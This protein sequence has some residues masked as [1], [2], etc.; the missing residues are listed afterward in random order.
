LEKSDRDFH[1][2]KFPHFHIM[3]NSLPSQQPASAGPLPF[4]GPDMTLRNVCLTLASLCL[5]PAFASAQVTAVTSPASTVNVT[6]AKDFATVAFQDPWDMKQ[7]TDLGWHIWSKDAPPSGL[8]SIA[9]NQASTALNGTDFLHAVST[10]TSPNITILESSNRFGAKLGRTG[11]AY[12]ID[13]STYTMLSY[14]LCA[15]GGGTVARKSSSFSAFSAA[16][17]NSV[18][19]VVYSPSDS[20]LGVGALGPIATFAGCQ[21]YTVDLVNV[22]KLDV[23]AG[24]K[25]WTGIIRHLR[26]DPT[27]L[28][29]VTLDLDWVRL[30]QPLGTQTI[31]WSGGGAADIYLDNNN[32]KSDGTLGMLSKNDGQQPLSRLALGV[33]SPYTFDIATL[34]PG[35]YY[36][37]VCP[38]GVAE[39]STSCLYSP[40]RFD[41]NAIPTVTVTAPSEEG[42]ADDFATVQLNNAW[43]FD[44]LSD[45]DFSQNI[46]ATSIDPAFPVQRPD[47][48]DLGTVRVLKGTPTAA[49]AGDPYFYNLFFAGSGRGVTKKIDANRYR[50]LTI[51]MGLPGARDINGGSIA[52]VVWKTT[53]ET[54][55]NVSQDILIN[56]RAGVNILDRIN[57]DMKKLLLET[58]ASSGAGP[59]SHGVAGWNGQ[60]ENF[61]FDPHEFDVVTDFWVKQV[62]LAA[63]ETVGASNTYTIKWSASDAFDSGNA[64]GAKVS[65]FY[66]TSTA[67]GDPTGSR[68]AI[69]TCVD[70]IASSGQCTW[71]T[72]NVPTGTYFIYLSINDGVNTNTV[73]SKFPMQVDPASAV[74]P[75]MVL[76][77]ALLNFGGHNVNG[78]SV[79]VTPPQQVRLSIAGSGSVGWTATTSGTAAHLFTV[80]PSSGTGPAVLTVSVPP[81]TGIPNNLV[82]ILGTVVVSSAQ[83]ENSPQSVTV[84]LA[85]T[86]APGNPFGGFDTPADNATV[87]GSIA[88][89]GWVLD[90]IGITKLEIFRDAHP[91]DPPGAIVGGKV[92]IGNATLVDGART[93]IAAAFPNAPANY[94]AGWGYLMLTRGL[95]W[96]A[97]G[98]FKLYAHATDV[99][100]HVVVLGSKTVTV[101]NSASNPEAQ[102]PFGSI[103]TPEQGGTAS[104]NYPN[105]G[106]VL[107]PGTTVPASGVRVAI[108]GV[109]LSNTFSMSDR[110]DISNGFPGFNT[111]GAGRG[112][113]IDTTQFADGVHT[114]GWFVT[115]ALGRSEGIGSR[116]FR[117]T[118][119]SSMLTTT[120]GQ[121]ALASSTTAFPKLGEVAP[122]LLSRRDVRVGQLDRVAVKAGPAES[123]ASYA[124]YRVVDGRLRQL[125][126]G[127]AFDSRTGDFYWQPAPGFIG[128]YDFVF[129]KS[130][131]GMDVSQVSLRVTVG[132]S[133]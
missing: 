112:S 45:I 56:H 120:E 125:P 93:D 80:S 61:R 126:V 122:P 78:T 71:N 99:D 30:V 11:D 96:D 79:I 10:N 5:V 119:S 60:I 84:Y 1:I 101:N 24:I 52:R 67:S 51:D 32:I 103:D 55:E 87:Q 29:G 105:T 88:V 20:D 75:R 19:Y 26:L 58:D 68:T 57:V 48:T 69:A 131:Y 121:A 97:Q 40:G 54:A 34:S 15:S 28:S 44:A 116:F 25:Q 65:A 111:S 9:Y 129:V 86:G 42:S 123:M 117:I 4:Y 43:D 38:T 133:N 118:N 53:T 41:V 31:S 23:G 85:M 70:I 8:T 95:I 128:D 113:F 124:A 27:H 13:A 83:A 100:G 37:M 81:N 77:R 6:A 63:L 115:D 74:K 91:S 90:D 33:N 21:I 46:A 106:W 2:P 98:P 14:R 66:E 50:I 132:N 49:G 89:T 59:G 130:R 3:Y 108:D 109:F 94:N 36:A 22:G 16:E 47:G 72:G 102:K 110:A 104:G 7:N 64:T 39:G 12:A 127:S 114:I 73:Y 92:F 107:S 82:G 76:D 62:K 35:S 17:T 18:A